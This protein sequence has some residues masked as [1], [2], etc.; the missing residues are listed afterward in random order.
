MTVC[1]EVRGPAHSVGAA[2]CAVI[3]SAKGR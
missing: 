1:P 3:V 2:N